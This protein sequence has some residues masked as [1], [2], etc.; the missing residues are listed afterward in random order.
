MVA[1]QAWYTVVRFVEDLV[2]QEPRNVGVLLAGRGTVLLGFADR[3][4]LAE[5]QAMIG[6]FRELLDEIVSRGL[7]AETEPVEILRGLASRRF[8]H[9]NLTDPRGVGIDEEPDE[10]LERLMNSLAHDQSAHLAV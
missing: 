9:F 10:L 1:E 6:R 8:S 3:E 5:H 4:D 2:R 7:T